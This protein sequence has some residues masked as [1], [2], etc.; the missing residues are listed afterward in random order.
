MIPGFGFPGAGRGP[1][2]PD[3]KDY[4]AYAAGMGVLLALGWLRW[5]LVPIA[6]GAFLL[7]PYV[8]AP[9]RELWRGGRVGLRTSGLARE[10]GTLYCAE[11]GSALVPGPDGH[12]HPHHVCPD[13]EGKWCAAAGLAARPGSGKTPL[14]GWRERDE[15]IELPCP[16]CAAPMRAGTFRGDRFTAFRCGACDGY[17]LNRIDWVSFELS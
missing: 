8:V 12:A 4:V 3:P 11:C 15:K 6:I 10:P 5:W 1:S 13:C 7:W 2:E 9:L 16:R 17:W 14:D